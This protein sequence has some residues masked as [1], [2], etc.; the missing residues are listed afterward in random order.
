[1]LGLGFG[2]GSKRLY[3]ITPENILS[4][5]KGVYAHDDPWNRSPLGLDRVRISDFPALQTLELRGLTV[6]LPLQRSLLAEQVLREE[7]GD[8]I[9][10]A[11]AARA[12]GPALQGRLHGIK[13]KTIK[14]FKRVIFKL[15]LSYHQGYNSVFAGKFVQRYPIVSLL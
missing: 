8:K 10:V 7:F 15:S 1:M 12:G 3:Y 14:L 6:K 4:C 9:L 2:V 11:A 13:G 5:I